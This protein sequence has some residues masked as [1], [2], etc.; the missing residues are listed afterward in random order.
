[1]EN[2]NGGPAANG[3]GH[4]NGHVES[5]RSIYYSSRDGG[6]RVR[7]LP[8][9]RFPKCVCRMTYA[10]PNHLVFALDDERRQFVDANQDLLQE[11]E[12]L[13]I[14]VNAQSTKIAELEETLAG[15][16]AT[17]EVTCDE[18]QRVRA[19]LFRIGEEVRDRASGIMADA[20][21]LIDEVME[22]VQSPV[23]EDTEEDP[24]EDPEEKVPP[25]S[26]LRT[27]LIVTDL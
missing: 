21:M 14:M 5:L 15:K 1:M 18:F 27:R 7:Y 11:V 13:S 10:Y 17:A 8:F 22:V 6:A 12:E 16:M 23:Q 3:N 4:A 19:R 9:T 24:E 26:P 25:D 20:T 2:G